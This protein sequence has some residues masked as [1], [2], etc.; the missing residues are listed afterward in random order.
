M[1]VYRKRFPLD[2]YAEMSV[3]RDCYEREIHILMISNGR[4]SLSVIPERGMDIGEIF[5]DGEK[6]S[7]NK[8]REALL[9]PESVDLREE[10]GWD[11]GF[12]A[13]VASLGPE[14]FGTPDEIRT[15]HG[16]GSYSPADLTSLCVFW[17]ENQICVKGSVSVKGYQERPV[18]EKEILIRLG[19]RSTAFA[20]ED[21]TRNLTG[22]RQPLDDGFH[23]Q[24]AGRFMAQ[25]GS[26]VLPVS[27]GNMLLRDGAPREADAK[28]IYDFN[29]ELVPIRCYQYV[30]GI[31]HGLQDLGELKAYADLIKGGE[32]LTAEML[33]NR[34]RNKAAYVIRPLISYPRSLIAK[35]AV[36]E[37]M[38]SL[39]PC[40]TRPN[41]LRQK[42]IDGELVWLEPYKTDDSWILIGVSEDRHFLS[43][44]IRLINEGT[45]KLWSL[46]EY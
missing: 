42:E 26:Y 33:V 2:C 5:L 23:I 46:P 20:R 38:Y 10:G 29:Q 8:G 17:E 1:V 12:Y 41:S 22:E 44:M 25:G 45:D 7:W 6:V 43:E 18:Y 16:T 11:K 36:G 28:E 27:Q 37:P 30:P 39:E 14:L 34:R 31:V 15:V 9:H 21:R 19:A 32:G 3:I 13:A 35:R 4:L 40:R 24:L